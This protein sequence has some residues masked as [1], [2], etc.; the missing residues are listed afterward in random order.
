MSADEA[1]SV[2]VTGTAAPKTSGDER[3]LAVARIAWV[4]IVTMMI[5]LTASGF[6]ASLRNWE[7]IGSRSIYRAITS[8]GIPVTLVT[9]VGLILPHVVYVATGILI[10]LRRS[11][12]WRAMFFA[13]ALMCITAFRPLLAIERA[14]PY[15]SLAVE[16]VLLVGMVLHF[17][18]LYIFPNGRF[19]PS[20]TRYLML[21]AI[22]VAVIVSGPL[23]VVMML[24][25]RPPAA[26][27]GSVTIT[28]ITTSI[29][30]AVGIGAQIYRFRTASDVVERQQIKLVSFPIGMLLGIL[31]LGSL[32]P[33]CS[34]T[35]ITHGSHGAC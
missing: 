14:S 16:V 22:P 5:A 21:G 27:A 10:F 11:R 12:D 4:A 7:L 13:L 35:R 24:P 2:S 25:D 9:V 28:V 31:M 18:L 6:V 29:F 30:L 32:F 34:R 15:L 26:A 20:W 33:H 3:W 1:V 23:R 8:A 19:V 17:T